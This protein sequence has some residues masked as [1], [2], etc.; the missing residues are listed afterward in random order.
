MKQKSGGIKRLMEFTGKHRGLLTVSRILSGIS[1][2]FILGPFLCVY[3]AARD[4]VGVF[5][6]TPLDTNS[7]VRW[8]LLALGLEL[9][10][11]LLYFSALLCSH[12]VAFHTEKNLKMAALKHL[13]KMPMGYFDANPS[14]KLR[15]IIDDNSFQTETFIAHQL[16][17]L[18]GAQVTMIVSLVLM[19]VFD[20][21][22]GI[23]LLLLFGIGFFLQGSLMGKD[24]M[25][26]MQTYQDSLETMNHEAVEYI[27]GISVYY[28]TRIKDTN[29]KLVAIYAKTPE[30]L[31]NKETLAL[32]QIEN[33]T[34]HRKTPTVA[35]Y[36]EKWLL[37]QSVHVR[38]TTLTDYTSK[39]RR[40]IIAELGDKRMGEVSLDD[41][42]LAL[43]P[44][45]K[46]SAS[47]YKS[48]VILYK[49]IFRAAM[50]SRIIDHNP[51]IYL[52]T[53]GGGVPQEDRQA[54]TDEQV[55][56]LLDAI[57][58]LPPYVFVMIG[59][60]AGLRREEILALQWD[61]VY[62]DTDT[63]YL[64]V[65]RA[66][67]TEHNRPVISD[68]LKTKAAERNIPLPV[69]LAECLKAAKETS[70]SEYVVSNRDGEPLSYTQFKRLWQYIVTRTVKERSYYRYEDGKR[71]KHTVTPVLGE[72][73]AHNGKVVYS[74]DFE[75]TPHQLRH[76]YITNLIHASVDPKTVQYLAGHESSKITMDIYAKV[77]YNRP[78]ELV[79][80]M[81]CAF[82][83][84]DAA[85]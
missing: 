11:L 51:T 77:K 4:L 66:W 58:D 85:Q 38:A 9:I 24:S 17:D 16:P 63:P 27:R 5:A 20:W 47:V 12:V 1:S 41:I 35:E 67:H 56:R 21:R 13:A 34:F 69:C 55:E 31:Y 25:K 15:K 64:T 54:L 57:R 18:V 26:F 48:V 45:S 46:K 19:L 70:T 81:N 33:A 82:A 2:A 7:L 52:T 28:R 75:V 14:G 49:S 71:V 50:E 39:V 61:S 72:K 43:V 65:R 84:W 74:L 10:G 8:G 30:E 53:K 23:P 32:E 44:V 62:L 76:T 22:V 42:Q 78:D 68:E 37:M 36:C 6:G 29:G 80:S 73:A 83:S 40:H 3:F 60:Y 59:L 79:R